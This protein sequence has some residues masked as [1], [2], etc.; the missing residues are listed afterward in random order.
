MEKCLQYLIIYVVLSL[1]C[2]FLSD[3]IIVLL[4]SSSMGWTLPTMSPEEHMV[5]FL[6]GL[7]ALPLCL[8]LGFLLSPILAVLGKAFY[9]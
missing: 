5:L 2:A 6:T 7:Q 4:T 8:G 9:A 1:F 3:L